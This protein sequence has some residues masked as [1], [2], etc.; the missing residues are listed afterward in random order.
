MDYMEHTGITT[1]DKGEGYS[2]LSL[3]IGPNCLNYYGYVHGGVYFTLADSAAGMATNHYE[4]DYITLNSSINYLNAV[5]EGTIKASAKVINKTRKLVV[6]KVKT[7]VNNILCTE[8][9]FT[10]YKVK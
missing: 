7:Y 5:Q 3:E 4:G 1:I 9:T 8:S 10:M 6:I 2:N